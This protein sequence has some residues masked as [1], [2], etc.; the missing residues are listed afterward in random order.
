MTGLWMVVVECLLVDSG[1]SV[2]DPWL[3]LVVVVS[4]FCIGDLVPNLVPSLGTVEVV[5]LGVQ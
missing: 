4:W 5:V 1:Q 2:G 3:L